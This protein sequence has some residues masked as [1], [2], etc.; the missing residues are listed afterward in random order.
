M[1]WARRLRRVFGIEIEQCAYYLSPEQVI[2]ADA[3]ERS[4]LYSAGVLFFEMLS[5]KRMYSAESLTSLFELHCVAPI[6]ALPA[7]MSAY[8]PFFERLVA[9]APEDRFQSAADAL[10][11]LLQQSIEA[12]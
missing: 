6:P 1:N 11:A 9:K 7:A 8:Q 2:G 3:D 10:G 12:A 5:G 4:D